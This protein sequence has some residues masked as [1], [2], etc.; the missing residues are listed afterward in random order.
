[1]S[2]EQTLCSREPP[3][4]GSQQ[5]RV[6]EQVHGDANGGTGRRDPIAS[7]RA[8]RMGALPSL[9]RHIEMTCGVGHGSQKRQIGS[10][11]GVLASA[12]M[13]SA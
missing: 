6:E 8:R 12:S 5:G 13:R 1:M 2:V 4:H 3:A 9:D 10:V 7:L 11:S